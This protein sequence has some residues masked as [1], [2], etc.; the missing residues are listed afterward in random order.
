MVQI[1]YFLEGE[2]L[3]QFEVKERSTQTDRVKVARKN[4]I[5]HFD[6]FILDSGRLIAER[7]SKNTFTFTDDDGYPWFIK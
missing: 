2:S 6:K 4:D 3:G 5:K 1:E 7:G